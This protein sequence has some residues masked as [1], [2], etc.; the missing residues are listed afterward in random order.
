MKPVSRARLEKSL[1]RVRD[2][3]GAGGQLAGELR[4]AGVTQA[5]LFP[6]TLPELASLDYAG[7]CR[8]AGGV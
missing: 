7:T 1:D 5:R 3:L 6:Q 4:Q 2:S 8:P